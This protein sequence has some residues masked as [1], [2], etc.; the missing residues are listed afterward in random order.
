MLP[1]SLDICC[2]TSGQRCI[3]DGTVHSGA[4]EEDQGGKQQN[5]EIAM[6]YLN[7]HS[8]V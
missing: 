5:K 1:V 2:G 4:E 6:Q 3:L 8:F 7:I